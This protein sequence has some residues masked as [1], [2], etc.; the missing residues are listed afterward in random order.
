MKKFVF[1]SFFVIFISFLL[2]SC[3]QETRETTTVKTK[4][5][6]TE[7][8]SNGFLISKEIVV[9]GNTIW[10]FSEKAYGTGLNWRD[11]VSQNPFLQQPGRVYYDDS[12]K[13]WVV[14]IYPG[15]V[16]KIGNEVVTPSYSVEETTTTTTT[17]TPT[18]LASVPWWGWLLIVL[19]I[20]LLVWLFWFYCGNGAMA[21]ASS[22]SAV[23]VN[24]LG[25]IDRD[26]RTTLLC[27]EQD[28]RD[29]LVDIL[30]RDTKKG[31]IKN[32]FFSENREEI[33]VATKYQRTLPKDKKIED[34]AP[35]A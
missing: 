25:S 5:T 14:K 1:I 6:V 19:S 27:R 33:T 17:E 8:G 4:T 29:R 22:S 28:R 31:R 16:V 24:I 3:G 35:Q 20:A 30:C 32:F 7:P 10:G 26:T 12:R 23:H 21:W 34:R 9:K 2:S 18:G 11:I 15:E 13:M